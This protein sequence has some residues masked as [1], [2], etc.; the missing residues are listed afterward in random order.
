MSTSIGDPYQRD[1]GQLHVMVLGSH[2][3]KPITWLL[4][5][6]LQ[7]DEAIKNH[8]GSEKVVSL[9]EGTRDRIH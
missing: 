6:A 8:Y 9:E 2:S 5:P 7:T 3:S 1:V 4:G